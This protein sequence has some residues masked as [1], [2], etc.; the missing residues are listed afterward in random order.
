MT[1]N[2]SE[3]I[4]L[5]RLLYMAAI[6][7]P[8]SLAGHV[9]SLQREF[10]ENYGSAAAL[11]PPVHITVSPPEHID[12]LQIQTYS[13]NLAIA[14]SKSDAFEIIMDGFDFFKKNR[15]VFIRVRDNR[16]L[17][18]LVFQFKS[19][20]KITDNILY[21]P[22]VTIGY[23]NLTEEVFNR[24]VSDYEFRSFNDKFLANR[25]ELWKHN[26]QFWETIE[27]YP[28]NKLPEGEDYIS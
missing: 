22:H 19:L 18:E 3:N 17:N 24:I 25:V 8:D 26:G 23:R 7:L 14:A 1:L 27:S 11:R 9:R 13:S 21:H 10:A 16:K 15:V 6:R 20:Q 4:F 28:F 12:A 5:M 2:F